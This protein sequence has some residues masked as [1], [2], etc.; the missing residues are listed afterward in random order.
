[1]EG[2]GYSLSVNDISK[3]FNNKINIITYKMIKKYNNIDELIK[4]FNK[5]II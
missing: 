4:P 2:I 5:T 3:I 1:M